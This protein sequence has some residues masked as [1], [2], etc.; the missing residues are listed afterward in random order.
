MVESE[1][2]PEEATEAQVRHRKIPESGSRVVS[3]GFRGGG[4]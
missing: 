1:L 4:G 3:R 2:H